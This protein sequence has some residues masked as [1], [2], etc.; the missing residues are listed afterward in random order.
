M[1]VPKISIITPTYNSES[2]IGACLQSVKNQTYSNIEHIIID[3]L[4]T[5][6]T[7][8]VILKYKELYPFSIRLISEKDRGIYD[9]MNKGIKSAKGQWLYFLG[10][11]DKFYNENVLSTI[12]NGK[13]T[14][15]QKIIYGNVII[16]GDAGW[17]KNGQIYD[18]EFTLSKLIDRNICHQAIF[19]NKIVFKR[20][21][22]FNL[23]F[24][25]CADWDM[26]FRLWATFPFT[27]IDLIVAVFNG[28]NS[29]SKIENN[30]MEIDK[31]ESIVTNFKT[32]VI[33]KKF[34]EYTQNFLALS[35]Y[36][37]ERHKHLKSFLLKMI[38][39]FHIYKNQ[40]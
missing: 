12:F 5:D 25:I 39:N 17:A 20:C 8:D 16:N 1:N 15:H 3:N 14:N 29:S 24:N 33:S 2:K 35:W 34:S 31:W 6:K 27:Y 11:D 18:G 7:I 4:S 30:Y 23:K 38:F 13:Q 19:F 21:G 22:G 37:K 9:A 32:R 10:S 36:Y 28:G 40:A 26:N